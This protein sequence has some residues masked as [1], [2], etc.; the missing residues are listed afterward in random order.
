MTRAYH[1][2]AD[3]VLRAFAEPGQLDQPDL[4]PL[5]DHLNSGPIAVRR[6]LTQ[7]LGGRSV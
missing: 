2:A 1:G 3:D 5:L 6:E 4:K 7:T